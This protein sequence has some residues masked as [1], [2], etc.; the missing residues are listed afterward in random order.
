MLWGGGGAKARSKKGLASWMQHRTP[1]LPHSCSRA[2]SAGQNTI[3]APMKYKDLRE[4]AWSLTPQTN[5]T[6]GLSENVLAWL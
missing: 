1:T 6:E 5:R 4:E 2:V 3:E